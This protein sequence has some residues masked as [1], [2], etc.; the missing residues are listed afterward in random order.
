MKN[1]LF[2]TFVRNFEKKASKK[3]WRHLILFKIEN[4]I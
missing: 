2:L 3:I 1:E 4:Y